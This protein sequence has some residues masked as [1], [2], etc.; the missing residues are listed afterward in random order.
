VQPFSRSYMNNG[1]KIINVTP[2]IKKISMY[3]GSFIITSWED[4]L[5]YGIAL[6]QTDKNKNV[7]VTSQ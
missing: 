1:A 6:E 7:T 5:V 4:S 2:E 3:A